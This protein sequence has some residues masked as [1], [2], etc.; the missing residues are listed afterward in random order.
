M[1]AQVFLSFFL[2]PPPERP[3]REKAIVFFRSC[4]A[5]RPWLYVRIM[6]LAPPRSVCAS[7][8]TVPC[9]PNGVVRELATWY[10]R[11]VP[12]L[13]SIHGVA[14]TEAS[15]FRVDTG[16]RPTDDPPGNP[17]RGVHHRR[18]HPVPESIHERAH[19]ICKVYHILY[20]NRYGV[21]IV[22]FF[23]NYTAIPITIREPGLLTRNSALAAMRDCLNAGKWFEAACWLCVGIFDAGRHFFYPERAHLDMHTE[24]PQVISWMR[25]MKQR[26]SEWTMIRSLFGGASNVKSLCGM[27][28]LTST[29]FVFGSSPSS[30]V[31]VLH[32][33]IEALLGRADGER[34]EGKARLAVKHGTAF[35]D[36]ARDVYADLMDMYVF[37]IGTGVVGECPY[38]SQSPDGLAMP[39]SK[40][41]ELGLPEDPTKLTPA[42]LERLCKLHPGVP[43]SNTEPRPDMGIPQLPPA[44]RSAYIDVVVEIKCQYIKYGAYKKCPLIYI[45]QL[46]QGMYAHG[47]TK[48]HF[49]AMH[50]APHRHDTADPP[51]LDELEFTI[52]E[53]TV[54][55]TVRDMYIY[56]LSECARLVSTPEPAEDI[57][58]PPTLA[59]LVEEFREYVDKPE[60]F[61]R[62][63][64]TVEARGCTYVAQGLTMNLMDG[65]GDRDAVLRWQREACKM[66]DDTLEMWEELPPE[67]RTP[68]YKPKVIEIGDPPRT[69]QYTFTGPEAGEATVI[70]NSRTPLSYERALAIYNRALKRARICPKYVP[71]A[72]VRAIRSARTAARNAAEREGKE[73]AIAAL[74]AQH[75][76]T[77]FFGPPAEQVTDVI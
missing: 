5:S 21:E 41:R 8:I 9:C 10:D 30:R 45:G 12:H 48:A 54:S 64:L 52:E 62:R 61:Q 16:N 77:D 19:S 35:E 14:A 20:T 26:S 6:L 68:A 27:N 7:D 58:I 13:E 15:K 36:M 3:D 46:L 31:L 55:E 11:I 66:H 17:Y 42:D 50:Y 71:R 57:I 38:F 2:Y 18:A 40:A 44:R 49:V 4:P 69:R 59:K 72:V 73:E 34:I 33:A 29:E 65:L 56:I 25:E 1:R 53:V 70:P 28:D 74:D 43:S 75:S 60:H 24:Y 47:T 37:E 39:R 22:R 23:V 76:I 32:H 63:N 51:P 67:E